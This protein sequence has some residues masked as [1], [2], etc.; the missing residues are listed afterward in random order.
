MKD[1]FLAENS[2]CC[3]GKGE[4]TSNYDNSENTVGRS[5]I[6]NYITPINICFRRIF[7]Q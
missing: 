7:N 3:T 1:T 2:N 4:E 5:K 6:S